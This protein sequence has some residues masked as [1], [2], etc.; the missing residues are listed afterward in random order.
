[1]ALTAKKVYAIL[2]R[3]ISDMEAKLNSPLRYRGT[4][5][6]ADLLP[7]NPDIGDMYNIESKSVYGEAGMNV[8]WNGVVWDTMGAPIDMSLYIKSSELADWVKQQNKPTYTAEEVGALPADTKIPSKTSDLQNDSGF[9]TKIPDNYLSGTDKTLSAPGKAA[10]AKAVGKI[11]DSLKEDLSTKITKF[12]ASSQG[13]THITDSDNGKIQ[14]MMIYGKSSQDGTPTPENPVEIKSVVNPT[15]KVCGKN[16][17]GLWEQGFISV[18]NGISVSPNVYWIHSKE[19]TK[20]NAKNY[21]FSSDSVCRAIIY[22]YDRNKKYIKSIQ[23]LV[24]IKNAVYTPS[25]KCAYIKVGYNYNGGSETITHDEIGV[26]HWIQ[27]EFGS[28]PTAFEPYHEQTVTLPYTLNAIPVNSGGNV[29]IDGQQYIADYVDVERG[30]LVRMVDSS[31]L[32]NTQSIIGKTEWLLAEQQETD[33]TTEQTQA[34]KAL[35]TYYPTTNIS[36]NSEQLDGYTVFNYPIPFEDEWNKTQKEIGG[37]KEDIGDLNSSIDSIKEIGLSSKVNFSTGGLDP[38]NG[39]ITDNAERLHSDIIFVR[40]GSTIK[41]KPN[42][43]LK[44]AVYKYGDLLGNEFI[45]AIAL[46]LDDYIFTDDCYI[47]IL[48]E[49]GDTTLLKDID[50]DLFSF[51]LNELNNRV[52]Y[53]ELTEW[54]NKGYISVSDVNDYT[55]FVIKYTAEWSFMVLPV[56]SGDKFIVSGYGGNNAKLYAFTDRFGKVLKR[57]E[58]TNV[59]QKL[60]ITSP[61]DGYVIFNVLRSNEHQVIKF[62]TNVINENNKRNLIVPPYIPSAYNPILSVPNGQTTAMKYEE[63]MESWNNLQKK[64]PNYISKTNLGKE[65]SGIL[66]MYRYDFIPEIVPLEASVQDGMNK[67][68]TKND[69]PIVIMGACIHGAE[70]P[71]AK[72]L[73]NLMTLIANAKDY[74]ILGW[75]RNN[76]H[77]VIIPL[78]NPWGYKNNKRTNVNQVDLNRNFEPYW[79]KGDNTT[80]NQR[81]RGTAPLS[82]K[83]AQ[84]IDSI[85][86]ECADKAVCY[87]SFH[88]HGVFTSYSMMTNFSSPALFLLNDMQNIGMSV[89]KMIT[90]SGWTNHNLPEDS[91]YIGCMEM[92]YG[93]A[94][95]SYQGAKYNIPSACPEVMYRYYDGGTGEVYNTDLDCM[96]TEYILYAVANACKKFLY[97]N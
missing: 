42:K 68:Y 58:K 23:P 9:L 64:Y 10:D 88:T 82:E 70:R 97:G 36:V 56:H 74:S 33:L 54:V 20:I 4:V 75:L 79:E 55:K 11:T 49:S 41:L 38:S 62:N 6:T 65:T 26:K 89:T 84:Y 96:N 8:A 44:F 31:K 87:Y 37:L 52:K 67:I 85:L 51:D 57:T 30:K 95:A 45:S 24:E 50:F 91:G 39:S 59:I 76:I 69:Y 25:S 21:A 2:K 40:K 7:L 15:V 61:S 83:E 16:L 92:A 77:F 86:K 12:Y 71:C 72:A 78:E 60:V 28:T 17:L 32:D 93:V 27:F 53:T 35:A 90:T 13:E 29:T 80:E 94:M 14:D 73:L 63:I 3:Q 81:Y 19:Y 1:M 34:L 43:N 22:E 48:I 46:S 47:R 66:D 5:A 18:D